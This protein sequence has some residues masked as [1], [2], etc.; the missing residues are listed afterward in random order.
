MYRSPP[1]Q[2]THDQLLR[3]LLDQ[4][5]ARAD[6][7]GRFSTVSEYTDT[8]SVYSRPNFSP[9]PS[10]NGEHSTPSTHYDY[11]S[12]VSPHPEALPPARSQPASMLDLDDDPR[13]SLALSDNDPLS[14]EGQDDELDATT[15]IS[16]LGPKMRFHSRAPWE[17]EGDPLEEEDESEQLPRHFPA[18]YPFSRSNGPKPVSSSR[19]SSPR[20]SFKS[21]PSGESARYQLPPKRSFDTINSQVS[22]SRGGM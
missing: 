8:P 1:P 15:R 9:K 5:A 16:Y 22:Y 19:S 14:G 13:S 10:D 7:H 11:P 2:D 12:P 18:A 6:V 20:P 3:A 21:R 17:L 4:R